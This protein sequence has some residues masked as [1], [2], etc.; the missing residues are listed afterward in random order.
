LVLGWTPL[1]FCS[2]GPVY[3]ANFPGPLAS[4]F[5]KVDCLGEGRGGE[6]CKL[7]LIPGA[8]RGAG[9]GPFRPL[10]STIFGLAS[11]WD[12]D[13]FWGSQEGAQPGPRLLFPG[14]QSGRIG[15]DRAALHSI[16]PAHHA[17]RR[18]GP[19]FPYARPWPSCLSV[20]L[21]VSK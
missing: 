15:L 14:T 9:R 4:N 16:W 11:P 1:P 5:A 13:K 12:K 10:K 18:P 17:K 8:G 6:N 3:L 21:R 20:V 7:I 2:P 19:S